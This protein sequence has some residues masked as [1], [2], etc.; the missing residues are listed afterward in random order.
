MPIQI[1]GNLRNLN[2]TVGTNRS[3]VEASDK[4][5]TQKGRSRK[6]G[7]PYTNHTEIPG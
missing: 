2:L 7:C 5:T 4:K 3:C 1:G 6:V